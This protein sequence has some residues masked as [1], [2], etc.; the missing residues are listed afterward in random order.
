M[1]SPAPERCLLPLHEAIRLCTDASS[2]L[3]PAR[4]DILRFL[5]QRHDLDDE[6]LVSL[7]PLVLAWLVCLCPA[8]ADL[9]WEQAEAP[10][11]LSLVPLEGILR[12]QAHALADACEAGRR[13]NERLNAEIER[14]TARLAEL[15]PAATALLCEQRRTRAAQEAR[16]QAESR[17]RAAE[18][19]LATLRRQV[20]HLQRRAAPQPETDAVTAPTD[21]AFGFGDSR[22]D[23]QGFGF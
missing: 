8:L 6:T 23:A 13:E 4:R 14:L 11:T 5:L 7:R 12:R 19:E 2:T 10:G 17:L 1:T 20:E 22:A 3:T 18:D 9:R 16:Q 21:D 15:E